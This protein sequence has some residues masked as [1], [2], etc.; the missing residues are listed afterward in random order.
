MIKDKD[1]T[2]PQNQRLDFAGKPMYD[3]QK[4]LQD[5]GVR[6]DSTIS[7]FVRLQGGFGL[8][9]LEFNNLENKQEVSHTAGAPAHRD[10]AR[11]LNFSGVHPLSSECPFSKKSNVIS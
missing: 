6:K 7:L 4:T 5:Y 10:V 8:K 9:T 1:A 11:G 3:D 2:E